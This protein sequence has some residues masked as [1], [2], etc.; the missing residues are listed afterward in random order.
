VEIGL[1]IDGHLVL[2][3][4]E[5]DDVAAEAALLGY[6]SLWTPARDDDPFGLCVR[7][8]RASGLET[9]ISV[10]PIDRWSTDRLVAG[11]RRALDGTA[12]RFILGVGAGADRDA[13]IEKLRELASPLR[14]SLGAG[15]LYLGAL[16]P[17]MLHLAGERYDGAALNWCSP[18]QTLWS[19]E[20][21][22]AGALYAGRDPRDVRIH[23]YI[24]VCVDADI[25]AARHALAK[26]TLR[27]ALAR[28]DA[29]KTMGY[30]AHFAR[31]G[32]GE[33]LTAL[34]AMRDEG[35]GQDELA[36]RLPDELLAR[37]GWWGPP[38]GAAAG[39]EALTAGLDTAVV[40]VV[41]AKNNDVECVRL[42]MRSCVGAA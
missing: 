20:R 42:A 6:A 5:Q 23:Q 11:A 30:R 22:A 33:T 21:V 29:D 24:R 19:R 40:R 16:G 35:V 15:R 1:G 26:M 3:A 25:A 13:P 38:E 27:Y 8:H 36:D 28:P 4:T 41:A 9:G 2:S 39:F 14:A 12:G 37:V 17:R 31:M 7:W 34:E 18:E 32:F 10:L